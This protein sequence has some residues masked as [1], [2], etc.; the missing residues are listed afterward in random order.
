MSIE[1]QITEEGN[2]VSRVPVLE[3][4]ILQLSSGIKEGYR[5]Y[6]GCCFLALGLQAGPSAMP[7]LRYSYLHYC[8]CVTA[9]HTDIGVRSW[10][11]NLSTSAGSVKGKALLS[12]SLVSIFLMVKCGQLEHVDTPL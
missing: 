7:F 5:V 3:Q 12:L 2:T 11:S 1:L 6:W 9:L 8:V 10:D 4:R